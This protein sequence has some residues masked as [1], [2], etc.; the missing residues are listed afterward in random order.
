VHKIVA[1]SECKITAGHQPFSVHFN[2]MASQPTSWSVTMSR[3]KL[4]KL[5]YTE[6]DM[7][8]FR[9]SLT[10]VYLTSL[11]RKRYSLYLFLLGGLIVQQ[12]AAGLVEGG[13]GSETLAGFWTNLITPFCMMV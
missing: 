12:L 7:I 6:S 3:Q 8:Y 10:Q 2:Q 4:S 1:L 11:C 5:G 9:Y 13:K